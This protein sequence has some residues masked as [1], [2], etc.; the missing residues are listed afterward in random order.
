V[1]TDERRAYLDD[2]ATVLWPA[3]HTA[4]VGVRRPRPPSLV[5]SS[6]C[7]RTGAGPAC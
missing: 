6:W 7:C 4:L 3:P 1:V 5:A 2:V